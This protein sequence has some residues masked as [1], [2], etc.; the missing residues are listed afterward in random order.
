[1]NN[2]APEIMTAL[3]K[4]TF[5][6]N[7]AMAKKAYLVMMDVSAKLHFTDST[8]ASHMAL[9]AR[10]FDAGYPRKPMLLPP[11]SDPKYKEIRNDIRAA[12]ET[13]GLEF[14]TGNH[15]VIDA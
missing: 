6:G 11:F 5:E 1:M 2:W 7:E 14:T 3:V 15:N 8:I 13:L 10:G 12:F 9:Y 4:W